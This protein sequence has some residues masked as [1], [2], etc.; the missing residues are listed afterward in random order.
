MTY[1]AVLR[2]G[3]CILGNREVLGARQVAMRD[4]MFALLTYERVQI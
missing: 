3:G 2:Y 1:F 4:Y